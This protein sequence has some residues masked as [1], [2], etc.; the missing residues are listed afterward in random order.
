MKFSF[1]IQ[2]GKDKKPPKPEEP[3]YISE[4]KPM[5]QPRK[6]ASQ[7]ME[8]EDMPRKIPVEVIENSAIVD[9]VVKHKH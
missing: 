6:P 8:L 1:S 5:I 4:T 7:A 9:V 2:F 3:K